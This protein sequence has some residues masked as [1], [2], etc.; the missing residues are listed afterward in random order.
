MS[1]VIELIKKRPH[2]DITHNKTKQDLLGEV[3]TVKHSG[4]TMATA[5]LQTTAATGTVTQ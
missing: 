4:D 3:A 5:Y 1:G 2:I